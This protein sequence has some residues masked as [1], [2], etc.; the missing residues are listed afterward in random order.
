MIMAPM[1][2]IAQPVAVVVLSWNGKDDTLMC[3]AR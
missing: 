2:E 3:L 1:A